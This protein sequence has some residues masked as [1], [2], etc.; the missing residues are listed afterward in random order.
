M[1][2]LNSQV[3]L[4]GEHAHEESEPLFLLFIHYLSCH[5]LLFV[6]FGCVWYLTFEK[7]TLDLQ[8]SDLLSLGLSVCVN[9]CLNEWKLLKQVWRSLANLTACSESFQSES[10]FSV[11][12]SKNF[13][14]HLFTWKDRI[15]AGGAQKAVFI[16]D[17]LC[18]ECQKMKNILAPKK[19]LHKCSKCIIKQKLHLDSN[20]CISA[21]VSKLTGIPQE[22][23]NWIWICLD[24]WKS[25][26]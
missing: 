19:T 8:G 6:Q 13:L 12:P 17:D 20:A 22:Q 10:W 9:V 15:S 26:S 4:Q 16:T 5:V 11:K 1:C 3:K 14:R 25:Y 23:L 21:D 18:L 24:N 2:S 7:D